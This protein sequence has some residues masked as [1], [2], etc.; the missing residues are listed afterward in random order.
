PPAAV[1]TGDAGAVSPDGYATPGAGGD[2]G[3]ATP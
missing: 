1:G 3:A 2:G